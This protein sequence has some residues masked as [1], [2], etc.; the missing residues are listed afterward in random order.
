M[1]LQEFQASASLRVP[2]EESHLRLK[3]LSGTKELDS[4]DVFA[5]CASS[6]V[7]CLCILLCY[8]DLYC[9]L[10]AKIQSRMPVLR[11]Q[12]CAAPDTRLSRGK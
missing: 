9:Y 1:S 7:L 11:S 6:T 4:L 3:S 5:N 8:E 10:E 2:Q 12:T